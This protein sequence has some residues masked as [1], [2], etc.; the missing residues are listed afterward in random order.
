L[1]AVFVHLSDIHFGQEKNGGDVVINNDARERLID[2]AA[3]VMKKAGKPL[4]GIIVTGD[5]AYSAQPEEYVIA[6]EWLDRL[7]KRLGGAIYEIQIVPGNHD[8]DRNEISGA[9]EWMLSEVATKGEEALNRILDDEGDRERL[10]RRFHAYRDFAIGYRCPLDFSGGMSTDFRVVLAPNRALRFVRLNSALACSMR[11]AKGKLILGARQRTLPAG[12]AGEETVV[13]AHH[14]LSWFQDSTDA[15]RFLRGRGRVFISG[16]E[17]YPALIVEKVEAERDLMLLA[18]GATTPD[19]KSDKYTYKYNIIE[20]EWHE[21][22][23]ALAVTIHPRTWNDELKRF[24]EDSEFLAAS[25]RTTILSCPNF[26]AAPRGAG[27]TAPQPA[28]NNAPEIETVANPLT[29]G[30]AQVV[31]P[32]ADEKL[33][34]LRFFRDLTEGDRLKILASLK[35]IPDDLGEPLDH[36]ME[37]RL[38][39]AVFKRGQGQELRALVET[40]IQNKERR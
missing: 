9:T 18:A 16:H 30:G 38:F 5:V 10:Y 31:T 11:D 6:G 37:R 3:D 36:E 34:Q 20:F 24:Q 8:I 21:P 19:K 29:G 28:S 1:T 14:P 26:R 13:L 27:G 17:H 2:D 15:G 33:L 23:D 39:T 22:Q 7:A 25:E 4:A 40:A 32:S 12:E 35:A